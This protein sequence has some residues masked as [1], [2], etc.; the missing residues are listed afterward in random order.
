MFQD[1]KIFKD[2]RV[3]SFSV[4]LLD[5][6][7]EESCLLVIENKIWKLCLAAVRKDWN[8]LEFIEEQTSEICMAALE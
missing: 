4:A 1:K 8:M 5:N 6:S 2:Q 7:T 3:F